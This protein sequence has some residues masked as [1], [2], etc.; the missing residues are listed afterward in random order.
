MEAQSLA[1]SAIPYEQLL[2]SIQQYCFNKRIVR[3]FQYEPGFAELQFRSH[4]IYF[5]HDFAQRKGDQELS[6]SQL[7]RKFGYCPACVKTILA[8]ELEEPK[9]R[10]HH[11]AIDED[12][13]GEILEW[14]KAQAEKYKPI[15]C[16]DLR[17]YCEEKYSHLIS[18]E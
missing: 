12:S 3:A 11:L 17:H 15:I 4:Q 10:D 16:T 13:E 1:A 8:N 2:L 7:S 14:I 18:R 5:I 9:L 6:V